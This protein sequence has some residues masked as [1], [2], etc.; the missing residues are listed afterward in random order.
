MVRKTRKVDFFDLKGDLEALFSLS[1]CDVQFSA[2]K[3]PSLHPGQSA[4]ILNAEGEVIGLM[5]MLHPTLEKKLGFETPVFL[6]ELIQEF[7]FHKAIPKFEVLSKFPSVRRDMALLVEEK[8]TA[9]EIINVIQ[10]CQDEYIK[11]VQ[12]FD[13]YRGEGVEEGYKSVALSLILQDSAQTLTD[14]VIDAIF[15]KV[16]E[17]LS[18]NI[19]AKLRD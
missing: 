12:I 17:T 14:S 5:G 13:I 1:D 10:S 4:E 2:A 15:N 7:V 18:K 6:F 9:A 19:N 3:H 11:D 8:I 16:L